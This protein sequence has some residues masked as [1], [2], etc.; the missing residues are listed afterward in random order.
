MP[1]YAI[2]KK[3][4]QYCSPQWIFIFRIRYFCFNLAY[5]CVNFLSF[6]WEDIKFSYYYLNLLPQKKQQKKNV[7]QA[8]TNNKV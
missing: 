3:V 8:G 2:Q 5:T 1:Y 6:V 7:M 4:G